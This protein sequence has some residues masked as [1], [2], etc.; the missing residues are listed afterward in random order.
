ML[1]LYTVFNI[2]QG[3]FTRKRKSHEFGQ[4]FE[5]MGTH[6]PINRRVGRENRTLNPGSPFVT[7]IAGQ[8][9]RI[10]SEGSQRIHLAKYMIQGR[11]F[12]RGFSLDILVPNNRR[13]PTPITGR[14]LSVQPSHFLLVLSQ[15]STLET[16]EWPLLTDLL[17]F[18]SNHS[19]SAI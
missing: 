5:E 7:R 4:T 1:E 11:C 10:V 16:F 15:V 19:A 12:R 17:P 3:E 9:S 14:V 18:G 8:H 2:P 13:F 6:S